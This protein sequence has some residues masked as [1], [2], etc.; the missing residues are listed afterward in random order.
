MP[1]IGETITLLDMAAKA[2]FAARFDPGESR[3]VIDQ[4][5]RCRPTERERAR[6]QALDVLALAF[7]RI[8][9]PSDEVMKAWKGTPTAIKFWQQ[10]LSD[11]K[12]DEGL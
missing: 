7:D 12:K 11:V 4:Q 8:S 5:W 9:R 10:M 6:R 2:V 3:E 1:V